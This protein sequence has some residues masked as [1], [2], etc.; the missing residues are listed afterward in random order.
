[1]TTMNSLEMKKNSI[2]LTLQS[3][4]SQTMAI[5]EIVIMANSS[6][7]STVSYLRRM[8]ATHDNIQ[9]VTTTENMSRAAGRNEAVLN[10]SADVL[11]FMDDDCVL[12]QSNQIE[13]IVKDTGK[14]VFTCAAKRTWLAPEWQLRADGYDVFNM[15]HRLVEDFGIPQF[16]EDAMRGENTNFTFISFF[17]SMHRDD[18]CSLGG[19][20]ERFSGWGHEDS[21]LMLRALADG[22]SVKQQYETHDVIHLTHPVTVVNEEQVAE[23]W[24]ILLNTTRRL[25]QSPHF[26]RVH[27]LSD[28][29]RSWIRGLLDACGG[30]PLGALHE[31]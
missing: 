18:F 22:M 11:I 25:T 8:E 20:S 31:P 5:D 23:N 17:G 14:G 16:E 26:E 27:S 24:A 3:I 4:L 9:V 6:H 2:Q 1:M 10:S 19:F 29:F 30:T 12:T 13:R 15:A 28:P 21:D 7:D